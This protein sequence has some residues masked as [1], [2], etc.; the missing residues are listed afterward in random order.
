MKGRLRVTVSLWYECEPSGPCNPFGCARAHTQACIYTCE[1]SDL[2]WIISVRIST[3][4]EIS[5]DHRVFTCALVHYFLFQN[6]LHHFWPLSVFALAFAWCVVVYGWSCITSPYSRGNSSAATQSTPASTHARIL[7]AAFEELF[8]IPLVCKRSLLDSSFHWHFTC[9]C[10]C[11]SVAAFSLLA[12]NK[13]PF[14]S[15][16]WMHRLIVSSRV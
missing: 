13:L 16:N 4:L 11:L 5:I 10:D 1:I 12:L 14:E 2:C 7:V 8:S 3:F 15:M 6:K 9:W